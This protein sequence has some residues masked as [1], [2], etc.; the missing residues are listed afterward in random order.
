MRTWV[1]RIRA[2]SAGIAP[3]MGVALIA[4]AAEAQTPAAGQAP[5]GQD[6]PAKTQAV[7]TDLKAAMG[8]DKAAA[9]KSLSA[10]GSARVTFG[11]REATND[12]QFKIVLPDHIQRVMT[13]EMPNGMPGPRRATKGT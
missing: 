11:D 9:V 10:E 5:A 13:P 7:L 8:G 2:I 4:A 3:V 1:Q 12:V 6:D